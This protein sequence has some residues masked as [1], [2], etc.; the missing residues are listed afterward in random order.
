MIRAVIFD[1]FGVLVGDGFD[2]TYRFAGGNPDE[3]K[4]FIESLLEQAN[5]GEISLD[6]FRNKICQQLGISVDDYQKAINKA[7]HINYQLLNYIKE[8]KP[9]YKTAILS[10]VNKGGLERRIDRQELDK[11]FDQMIVSGDVGYIKPELEIYHLT[12]RRLGVNPNE[13]VFIDDR[14]G[15]VNAAKELGMRGI[16]YNDF[17]SM[18][19]ELENYLSP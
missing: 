8:L 19:K 17:D 16:V 2:S 12:V 10:N 13:C 7:E 18:K 3:D 1:F 15:Y 14:A 5:R 9:K 11:H 4:S 6:D